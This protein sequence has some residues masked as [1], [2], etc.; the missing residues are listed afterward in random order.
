ML[1]MFAWSGRYNLLN[2]SNVSIFQHFRAAA[3]PSTFAI[4]IDYLTAKPGDEIIEN[5][6]TNEQL[7]IRHGYF[8]SQQH[9]TIHFVE[10]LRHPMGADANL[11]EWLKKRDYYENRYNNAQ[12]EEERKIQ[13]SGY[14]LTIG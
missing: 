10:I 3:T 4:R 11:R 6:T 9:G 5:A 2:F 1:K 12:H 8:D 7:A 14:E 13:I